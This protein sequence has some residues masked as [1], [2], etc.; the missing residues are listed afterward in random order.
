[1]IFPFPTLE[2]EIIATLIFRHITIH[3]CAINVKITLHY[4]QQNL[5][6]NSLVQTLSDKK[7]CS[8]IGFIKP[9]WLRSAGSWFNEGLH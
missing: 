8:F 5:G 2:R 3:L 1:M 4:F 6:S 9:G 7:D